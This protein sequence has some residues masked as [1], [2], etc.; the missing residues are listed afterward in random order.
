MT[1]S[2]DFGIRAGVKIFLLFLLIPLAAFAQ[3]DD[4]LAVTLPSGKVV[5]FQ[6]GEQR[7]KFLAAQSRMQ[8]TATGAPVNHQPFGQTALDG[9]GG[10][11][12]TGHVEGPTA[13]A[14]TSASGASAAGNATVA[15]AILS[16][17]EASGVV[18]I[19]AHGGNGTI[20]GESVAGIVALKVSAL[21]AKLNDGDL[22]RVSATEAGSY[23]YTSVIGAAKKVR[24]FQFVN[25]RFT[26]PTGK[27]IK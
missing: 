5:H 4:P 9:G 19:N 12:S 6:T 26:T 16:V 1:P 18:I 23:N 7:D 14:G 11:L 27:K 21:T 2:C 15:G 10:G 8:P 17:D 24:V 22:V 20:G 13:D 25:G 3:A